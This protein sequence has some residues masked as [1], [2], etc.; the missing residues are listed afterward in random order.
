[1]SFFLKLLLSNETVSLKRWQQK[2]LTSIQ[3]CVRVCV[4]RVS[5][6]SHLV[7]GIR[8]QLFTAE[9]FAILKSLPELKITTNIKLQFFFRFTQKTTSDEKRETG[10]HHSDRYSLDS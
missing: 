10:H 5:T 2:V 9:L 6:A 3:L 4:C 7:S 8:I 1:M